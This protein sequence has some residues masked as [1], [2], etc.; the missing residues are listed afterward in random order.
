MH[1]PVRSSLAF[2]L[3][4]WMMLWCVNPP[5]AALEGPVDGVLDRVNAFREHERLIPL[6]ASDDLARVAT[7]HAKDMARYG[8]L[9]HIDRA[10]K[11]PLE[12]AQAA[13][14][15][16]FALLAENI[17]VSDAPRSRVDA[18]FSA[19]L[20]SPV[21]RANLTNPAFNTT[22]IGFATGRSG[23]TFIVQLFATY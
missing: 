10:G 2:A 9:D 19:W 1:T 22:G 13:G 20:E 16:G 8:Y 14:L 12:R 11:N 21:H 17:G 3:G 18:I 6:T 23:Q 15:S 7:A 5:I 4:L